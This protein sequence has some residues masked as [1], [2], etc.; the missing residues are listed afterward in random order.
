MPLLTTPARTRQ[1]AGPAARSRRRGHAAR[2]GAAQSV[3]RERRAGRRG[4]RH[5]RRRGG[6]RAGR[7]GAARGAA[8]LRG[9]VP[10]APGGQRV[11][12]ARARDVGLGRALWC[13]L[14]VLVLSCIGTFFV[15]LL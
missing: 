7:G 10:A 8:A 14:V 5:G 15:A 9:A 13:R 11:G 6:R 12:A 3:G 1:R 4:R 2:R